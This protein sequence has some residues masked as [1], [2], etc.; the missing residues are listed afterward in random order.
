MS[1]ML[2]AIGQFDVNGYQK[3]SALALQLEDRPDHLLRAFDRVLSLR[4]ILYPYGVLEQPACHRSARGRVARSESR[5]PPSKELDE[6]RGSP[7]GAQD[8]HGAASCAVF[9]PSGRADTF[10]QRL[11]ARA[12]VCV[13]TARLVAHPKA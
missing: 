2:M 9:A 3:E 11:N 10:V 1:V 6:R 8:L 5:K 7:G 13:N 12:E 4:A